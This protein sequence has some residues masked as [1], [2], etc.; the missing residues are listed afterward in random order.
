MGGVS[1]RSLLL[2]SPGLG[3]LERG[4]GGRGGT[5]GSEEENGEGGEVDGL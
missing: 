1:C 5:H 4:E 2:G 3:E